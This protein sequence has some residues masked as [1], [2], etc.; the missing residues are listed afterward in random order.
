MTHGRRKLRQR[1]Q[2]SATTASGAQVLRSVERGDAEG[3]VDL[4]RQLAIETVLGGGPP[5]WR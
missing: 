4:E 5:G 3:R 1:R 2:E